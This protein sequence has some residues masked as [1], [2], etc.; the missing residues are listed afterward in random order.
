MM[1]RKL[2]CILLGA[3]SLF[4]LA[5]GSAQAG[6]NKTASVWLLSPASWHPNP[7]KLH[8][9]FP[10]DLGEDSHG[11]MHQQ[12]PLHKQDG[13]RDENIQAAPEYHQS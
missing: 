10:W 13:G 7:N 12:Q 8:E 9:N 3:F 2:L 5:Q 1:K 11:E 4:A 6:V